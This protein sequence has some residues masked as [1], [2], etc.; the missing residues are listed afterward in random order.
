MASISSGVDS[1]DEL[2]AC[3]ALVLERLSADARC[4]YL[5]HEDEAAL[6]NWD[7]EAH[8][9]ELARARDASA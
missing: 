2:A 9:K 1:A 6:M 5:T 8:R 3:L 7:A 4:R